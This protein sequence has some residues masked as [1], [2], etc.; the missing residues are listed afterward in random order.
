MLAC[1][2]LKAFHNLCVHAAQQAGGA[3]NLGDFSTEGGEDVGE[4]GRNHAT[5]DDDHAGGQ[6]IQT[7]DGVVGVHLLRIDAGHGRQHGARASGNHNLSTVQSGSVGQFQSVRTDKVRVLSIE[8]HVGQ[9]STPVTAPF[10]D[11]VDTGGEDTVA[12]LGPVHG[13]HVRV[14]A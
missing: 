6:L 1:G 3:V 9:A 5:A 2:F 7:H 14:D 11:T 4:L 13:I 10:R 8:V 12:N